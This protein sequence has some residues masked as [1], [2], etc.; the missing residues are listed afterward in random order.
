MV[1]YEVNLLIDKEIYEQF[2]LWLN[3]HVKKMLQFPGFM[4]AQVLKP[5]EDE[6]PNQKKLTVH[7][8]LDN[9]NALLN[10][11]KH[12]AASMRDEGLKQFQSKFSAERRVYEIQSI[13]QNY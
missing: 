2:Q 9:H 13:F 8:Q 6:T 3:D 10:Y 5:E 4:Q 11:F 7:Y 12:F 1:I